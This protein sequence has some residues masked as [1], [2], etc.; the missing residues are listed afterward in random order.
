MLPL[1][2]TLQQPVGGLPGVLEVRE[3]SARLV[4]QAATAAP[5]RESVRVGLLRL[6]GVPGVLVVDAGEQADPVRNVRLVSAYLLLETQTDPGA[7]RQLVLPSLHQVP[8]VQEETSPNHDQP[9]ST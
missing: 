7:Q 8:N 5:N 9:R 3:A 2:P 1:W 6:Q 4:S